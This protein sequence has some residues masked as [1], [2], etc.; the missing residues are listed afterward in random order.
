MLSSVGGLAMA[1]GRAGTVDEYISAMPPVA[2]EALAL[3]RDAIQAALPGCDESISYGMPTFRIDGRGVI[4]VGGWKAHYSLYPSPV[5]LAS[6]GPEAVALKLMKGTLRFSYAEPVPTRLIAR[7]AR[8][9]AKEAAARAS[10]KAGRTSTRRPAGSAR[11]S[12]V[13]SRQ[14]RS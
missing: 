14:A 10:T 11:A 1:A 3:V 7:I 8:L 5:G 9:L 13:R 4:Y 2:R 12:V 6:L